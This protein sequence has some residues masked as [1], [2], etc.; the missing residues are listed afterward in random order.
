MWNFP[1]GTQPTA[2]G[3]DGA[4]YNAVHLLSWWGGEEGNSN[5][6]ML[7]YKSNDLIKD[8]IQV[9]MDLFLVRY[10]KVNFHSFPAQYFYSIQAK[11]NH[12]GFS[13]F[14]SNIWQK[15]VTFS[16]MAGFCCSVWFC[17][18]C[19]FFISGQSSSVVG[20]HCPSPSST[21][22]IGPSLLASVSTWWVSWPQ[23]TQHSAMKDSIYRH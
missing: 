2:H 23:S 10:V 14:K 3:P 18:V 6:N 9:I 12:L 5:V 19:S 8:L 11:N 16:R 15:L 20:K 22:P 21:Q 4:H 1:P 7:N 13:A 17:L